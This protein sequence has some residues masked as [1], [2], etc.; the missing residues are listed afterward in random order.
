MHLKGLDTAHFLNFKK[1]KRKVTSIKFIFQ[2]SFMVAFNSCK[3]F[4]FHKILNNSMFSF[5]YQAFFDY[6]QNL[7]MEDD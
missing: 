7:C 1:T 4:Y 5:L 3:T 2:L 6:L